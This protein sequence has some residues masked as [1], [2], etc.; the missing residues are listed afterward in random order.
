ML[1][2]APAAAMQYAPPPPG[3]RADDISGHTHRQVI[4]YL[5]LALPILLVQVQRLRPNA[6]TD[7]WVGDSISAYYWTGAVSLFVGLLA[8]LS[9]FLLTYRGYA[10][11]SY[12]YDRGAAIIAGVAAAL[13][14]LFPTSPPSG[15]AP[16]PWWA[17]WVNTIHIAA[18]IVLFSMFAV[19]SLWLFRKTA[20]GE[21]PPAEKTR[22]NAIYLVCGIA[23]VASMIW[24]VV[25]GQMGR[26]IFWPESSALVFFA[27]S[28]L[29][30]GRALH[31]IKA[32]VGAAK[33]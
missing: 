25:W 18:A 5:G 4:G 26:S 28:W 27:W 29:V 21:Q 20:P 33:G 23:I 12:K 32:T 7:Q 17:S 1:T 6:P 11:E 16:L 3:Q 24:S 14:A 15:L 8:A 9:L 2:K 22:R 30:K 19:F 13:V 10:N 31:S